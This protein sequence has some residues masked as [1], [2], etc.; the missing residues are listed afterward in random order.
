M[1]DTID[2]REMWTHSIVAIK[3]VASSP[4]MT[5]NMSVA[6]MTF[7]HRHHRRRSAPIYMLLFNGLLI[8]VI[9]DG[10]RDWP[11]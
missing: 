11:A 8:G 10:V 2:R 3:P 6:L 9:G 4:I 7:A 5:N 1:V